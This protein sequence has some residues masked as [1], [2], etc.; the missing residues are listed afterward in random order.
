MQGLAWDPSKQMQ[1]T[2]RSPNTLCLYVEQA[3]A[4]SV[5]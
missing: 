2:T 4:D 1:W 5:N 3:R